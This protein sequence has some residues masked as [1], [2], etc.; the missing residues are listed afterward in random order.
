V[1]LGGG[2][3]VEIAVYNH[4]GRLSVP[5]GHSL[6]DPGRLSYSLLSLQDETGTLG[7][8]PLPLENQGGTF[9]PPTIATDI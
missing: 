4:M 7:R 6:A 3:R 5:H 9:D 1:A 2:S 8:S